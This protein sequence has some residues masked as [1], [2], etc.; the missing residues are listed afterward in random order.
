MKILGYDVGNLSLEH[1]VKLIQEGNE[2]KVFSPWVEGFPHFEK[3]APG[4]GLDGIQKVLYFFDHVNW[5]DLIVFFD[6]GA[7]D[8]VSFLRDKGYTVFGAGRKG[9][10]LEQNRWYLKQ[11][12]K[13]I[14]LPLQGSVRV[15]GISELREYLKKNPNKYVKID[16]FR[17]D[18]ESFPAKDYESV[19]LEL[20]KDEV[21]LGPFSEE[22]QFVVEDYIEGIE[23]GFDLFF[24]GKEFIKPMLYGFEF[25]KSCYLGKYVNELPKPLKLVADKLA[26][27]LREIDYRGP[28]STEIRITKEGKPYLIDICSRLPYP[29]SAVY[30]ESI[31]NYTEVVW[32]IAKAQSVDLKINAPYVAVLPLTSMRAEKE[33]VKLNFDSKLRNLVKVR[34]ASKVNNNYYAVKGMEVVYVLVATGKTIEEVKGKLEKTVGQVDALGLATDISLD[35]L[36]KEVEEAKEYGIDLT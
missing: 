31:Q 25:Q 35:P 26:P 27:Y 12:V 17:G 30:T 5:A 7:G 3:F 22:Y 23:P 4:L 13:E 32:K 36:L 10:E 8:L 20:N 11:V 28:I 1:F 16:I 33:W 19:K 6:I 34:V 9:E 2:V 29:L 14:G 21:A 18:I 24:N 15:K